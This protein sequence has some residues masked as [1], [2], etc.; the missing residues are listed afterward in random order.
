LITK[1][2]IKNFAVLFIIMIFNPAGAQPEIQTD[3]ILLEV[4]NIR[5]EFGDID[6]A[7]EAFTLAIEYNQGLGLAYNNRGIA[8][9]STGDDRGAIEDFTRSIDI[10]ENH[11]P[12]YLNRAAS[13][14]NLEDFYGAIEDYST[15][16]EKDPEN[17]IAW[18]GRGLSHL[19]IK[20][21][22]GACDDLRNA[23]ELG[24]LFAK[25]LL[26]EHCR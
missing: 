25:D 20:Y 5:H 15:V 14:Y 2:D 10:N 7:I 26:N 13:R 22:V 21:F 3:R 6:G 23:L 8:R 11:L 17:A 9:A 19:Q 24:Y 4:G 18:Y 1:I 12:A 16:I